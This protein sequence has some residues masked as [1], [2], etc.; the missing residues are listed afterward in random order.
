M[1]AKP[2][3]GAHPTSKARPDSGLLKL[4]ASER[5]CPMVWLGLWDLYP[6]PEASKL[7]LAE[8]TA[9]RWLIISLAE[10]DSWR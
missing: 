2:G 9:L 8:T 6:Q 1:L 5:V 7:G 4:L 3:G 10:L